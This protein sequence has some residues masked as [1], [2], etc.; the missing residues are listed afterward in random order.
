[1]EKI[2]S[3]I[4]NRE[5]YSKR[6][7]WWEAEEAARP[8]LEGL[9]ALPEVGRA[10]VAGSLRRMVETVG[11]LDFLAASDRPDPIMDWFVSQPGVK[12]VTARGSSKS[13]VRFEDGLQ[14]DLRVVPPDQYVFALHHFT[15]SKDHNV[16]MRGRAL[17]LGYSLSE[18]GLRQDD[19][20]SMSVASV[21][22]E[23]DLFSLL[24]L[25]YIPPELR[26]GRG[27]LE[28]A[29]NGD[30]PD[31]VKP[32]D[33]RGAFHNHTHASD[34]EN[35]LEDMTRAAQ[36]LGWEYFG[37]ADHSKAS[38]QANGLNEVRVQKQ[39][40]QVR[41]LNASGTFSCHVFAG[42]ECDILRDG[43]LDLEDSTLEMLDYVVV[44]VHSSFTL[45]EE[46]MTRR[47][48]RAVEHPCATMLGHLTGEAPVAQGTLRGKRG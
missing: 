18:W 38:V 2:L 16:A 9:R 12:E 7:L 6:H 25:P 32:G 31:L 11:D 26:E 5:A 13:S 36:D 33:L 34:G 43:S 17:S 42:V 39:L 1:M 41:R 48:I 30:L 23:S 15:G 47:I 40:E 24:G 10:E 3:G 20:K 22:E 27:E 29:E 21:R 14:A 46:Q 28:A 4:R 19:R 8:I 37:V 45:S 35:S 44:S